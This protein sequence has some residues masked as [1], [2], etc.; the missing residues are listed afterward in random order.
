VL[1]ILPTVVDV[2]TDQTWDCQRSG[3]SRTLRAAAWRGW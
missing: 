2:I 1:C 3:D